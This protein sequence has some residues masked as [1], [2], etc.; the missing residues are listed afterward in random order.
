MVESFPNKSIFTRIQTPVLES[1]QDLAEGRPIYDFSPIELTD[2]VFSVIDQIDVALGTKGIVGGTAKAIR[3]GLSVGT[4]ALLDA[5]ERAPSKA[6]QEEIVR[7]DPK[8]A[9]N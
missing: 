1:V 7:R 9:C 5:L 4:R 6:A 2:L 8:N 3:A